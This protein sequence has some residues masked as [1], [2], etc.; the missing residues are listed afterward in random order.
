LLVDS[1]FSSDGVFTDPPGFVKAV[2]DV[3]RTAG[4]AL[5]ADEVQPGFGRTGE[6]MWG[7]AHHGVVPDIVAMGKPMGNGC[8]IGAVVTRGR[9]SSPCSPPIS[10]FFNT[11]ATSQIAT[12]AAMRVLEAIEQDGY[13]APVSHQKQPR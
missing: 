10:A 1:I 2:V 9:T 4:G 3:T 13:A 7:F 6:G 8:P 12:A 5:N 11:F